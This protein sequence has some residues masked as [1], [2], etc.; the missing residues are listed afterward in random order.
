[1]SKG[2]TLLAQKGIFNDDIRKWRRQ[3][4]D[5]KT[6]A[7]YKLCF[8]RAHQEQKR[9]V[10]T[11]GKVWYTS[12]VQNI[13][14]APPPSPEEHHDVIKDIHTIVQVMQTQ[15]YDLEGLAQANAVLTRSNYAVMAKLA[16]MTVNINSIQMQLITLASAQTNQARPKQVLL[17]ELR[18]QFH[19]W[20]QNLLS[21]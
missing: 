20:K 3:S 16:H 15:C 9:A 8:H 19:S 13:H 12:T 17:L 2:I 14:G 4:A 7:K 5:L 21:K 6:W 11:A 1:M 18:E 10:T